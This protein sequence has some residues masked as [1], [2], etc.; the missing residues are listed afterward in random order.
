MARPGKGR[1]SS[2][3]HDGIKK[4]LG[5]RLA[6]GVIQFDADLSHPAEALPR[7]IE[8][9]AGVASAMAVMS[10]RGCSRAYP[11]TT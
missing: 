10:T 9:F 6:D 7:T 3:C 5:E 8:I 4:V 2:A 1:Y 11:L